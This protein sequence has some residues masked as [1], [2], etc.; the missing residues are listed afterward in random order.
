[1]QPYVPYSNYQRSTDREGPST[2]FAYASGTNQVKFHLILCGSHVRR[3]IC[4]RLH[5][6]ARASNATSVKERRLFAANRKST[7]ST[8]VPLTL[9]LSARC[10]RFTSATGLRFVERSDKFT[11]SLDGRVN[12]E[13]E[14]AKVELGF[15]Y[16]KVCVGYFWKL[17]SN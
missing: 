15:L 11:I 4:F 2:C 17:L 9:P 7:R 16:G 6:A 3:S 14:N 8:D 1:M 10:S 13:I 12:E 5:A